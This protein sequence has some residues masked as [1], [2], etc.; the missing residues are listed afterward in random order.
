MNQ[1]TNQSNSKQTNINSVKTK[2]VPSKSSN[3]IMTTLIHLNKDEEQ[4]E[5]FLSLA[6][7]KSSCNLIKFVNE[8]DKLS[9]SNT[10]SSSSLLEILNESSIQTCNSQ[11]ENIMND[12]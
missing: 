10:R 4:V 5:S 2:L 6:S 1:K 11:W 9:N 8:I 7:L 3:A 12:I